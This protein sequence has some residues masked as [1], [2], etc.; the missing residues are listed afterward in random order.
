MPTIT[1]LIRQK[2]YNSPNGATTQEIAAYCVRNG[3]V[4]K[5]QNIQK[6]VS[7]QLSK[8]NLYY[9]DVGGYY[10][11][12]IYPKSYIHTNTKPTAQP[13][14][15]SYTSSYQKTTDTF[16]S[17]DIENSS[18]QPCSIDI[19]NI[20]TEEKD[21]TCTNNDENTLSEKN[22]AIVKSTKNVENN[23]V[24]GVS[25]IFVVVF[26]I[27][28]VILIAF[29]LVAILKHFT[30]ILAAIILFLWLYIVTS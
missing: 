22:Y 13:K 5:T 2:L 15:A 29:A 18:E 27:L 8:M 14:T 26:V 20:I 24:Q 10:V 7:G 21:T 28:L 4:F 6:S 19:S 11:W 23:K 16:I 3:A 12:S 17:S 30:L 25:N 9:Y 1:S